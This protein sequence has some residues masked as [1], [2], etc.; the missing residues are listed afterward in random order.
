[1]TTIRAD[2]SVAAK[3]EVDGQWYFNVMAFEQQ[4][5]CDVA[6]GEFSLPPL[7]LCSSL[8]TFALILALRP[9]PVVPG[10]LKPDRRPWVYWTERV[11]M[12][13]GVKPWGLYN[14]DVRQRLYT[15]LQ[16]LGLK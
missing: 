12:L 2:F 8:A 11:G 13:N 4:D 7:L 10:Q 3:S 15:Y 14:K 16:A 9:C 1:M 6:S 5:C